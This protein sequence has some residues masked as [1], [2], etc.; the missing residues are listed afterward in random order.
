[1]DFKTFFVLFLKII[2]LSRPIP[3]VTPPVSPVEP[4]QPP[5]PTIPPI[6]TIYPNWGNTVSAHHN[7]RVICDLEGLTYDQKQIL[8]ACVY[9][10]SGFKVNP[11]PNQNKDPKTGVVWSTDYGIVQ[12]NDHFHIG[13][14]KDFPSVDYVISHPEECLRWMCRIYKTTGSLQPWSSFSTGAYK[15]W[16]GKV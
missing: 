13:E 16:L 8:T 5:A 7:V 15:K 9:Q 3:P 6:D 1:M 10:E 11:K 12:V 14:G 4:P 2:G